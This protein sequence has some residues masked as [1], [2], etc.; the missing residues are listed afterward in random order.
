MFSQWKLQPNEYDMTLMR[1]IIE[2]TKD[3]KEQKV[4]YDLIDYYDT[5]TETTSMARTTGYTCT[6]VANLLLE[7]KYDK[8][9]IIPLEILGQDETA[10]N[11]VLK[12]LADREVVYNKIK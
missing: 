6:A 5:K 7:N 2:G 9:G 10:Y 11:Y 4:E 1:I 3:G 12:Y 8:K